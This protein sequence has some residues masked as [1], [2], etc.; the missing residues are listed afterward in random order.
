MMATTMTRN[1]AAVVVVVVGRTEDADAVRRRQRSR[2]GL[3]VVGCREISERRSRWSCIRLED[4]KSSFPEKPS[5]GLPLLV[6]LLD[7]PILRR[8][9]L[10]LQASWMRYCGHAVE[11][12]RIKKLPR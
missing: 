10:F 2:E 11:H 5:Q 12:L 6:L 7:L 4:P 9:V 1:A 8:L 3:V